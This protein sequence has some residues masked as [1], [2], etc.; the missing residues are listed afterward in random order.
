VGTIQ[1]M[2]LPALA[3]IAAGVIGLLYGPMPVGVFAGAAMVLVLVAAFMRRTGERMPRPVAEPARPVIVESAAA[4]DLQ[5]IFWL[6][7]GLRLLLA[8]FANTTRLAVSVAPDSGF[9]AKVGWLI[10]QSW[11]EPAVRPQDLDG[12]NALS[13]YQNLNAVVWYVMQGNVK[14]I[15]SAINALVGTIAMWNMARLAGILYGPVVAKRAFVLGAFFPSIVLWTSINI[16]ESWG[17]LAISG[18]LLAAQKLRARFSV[19]QLLLMALWLGAI[20]F[21][22]PY[23]VV[24]LTIGIGMSYLTVR[25]RQIPYAVGVFILLFLFLRAAGDQIGFS[26]SLFSEESLETMHKIREGMATGGSAYGSGSDTRTF[27][28]AL[29]YLPKGLAGFLLSPFPWSADSW[30]QFLAIP[31]TLVWYV[32]LYQ[33]LRQLAVEVR[34]DLPRIALL[35]FIPAVVTVAYAMVEG[36]EGTAYRHRAQ[37][38]LLVFILTAA[39]QTRAVALPA[40]APTFAKPQPVL[41]R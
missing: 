9:Y 33:G 26:M 27:L 6:A 2:I 10:A 24:L 20:V 34:R 17:F 15:L 35:L 8:V 5:S 12:Y 3:L 1:A 36:N 14:Y 28:G 31:E 11:D 29:L 32:L 22:R 23:L 21:I 18:L 13:F 38:M 25:A 7:L 4:V 40:R 41:H 30:R 16:R 39:W 37:L 19:T